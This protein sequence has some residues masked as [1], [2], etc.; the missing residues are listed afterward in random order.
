MS[1]A[2]NLKTAKAGAKAAKAAATDITKGLSIGKALFEGSGS[3]IGN[4]TAFLMCAIA[5]TVD[6][7]ALLA[8]IPLVGWILGPLIY[9]LGL[10]IF[11]LWFKTVGANFFSARAT[12]SKG[13]SAVLEIIPEISAIIPGTT[14][15][16]VVAIVIVRMEEYATKEAG[17]GE[18]GKPEGVKTQTTSGPDTG[19]KSPKRA[20]E[21]QG[22]DK[23]P[24]NT[25]YQA[26]RNSLDKNPDNTALEGLRNAKV[27]TAS[28]RRTNP[29]EEAA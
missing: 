5:L 24:D 8:L 4:G 14:I 10:G 1:T 20:P 12:V 21:T 15:N 17:K 23:N 27:N 16:V 2:D 28:S 19:V 6:V 13:I 29:L 26:S 25:A 7:L 9:I 3:K 18:K 11:G 22:L